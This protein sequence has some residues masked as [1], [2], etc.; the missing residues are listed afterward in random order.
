[1]FE[2]LSPAPPDPILGLTEAYKKDPRP[3]KVNL[4]VGVYQN[5]NGETPILRAVKAAE[6]ALLEIENTKNYLPIPGEPDFARCVE[7]FLF[8]DRSVATARTA[9]AVGGTGALR[10][11]AQFLAEATPN[12]TVWLSAPTW[13]NHRGIFGAA[14][15][16]IQSYPYYDARARRLD[17]PA[18]AEALE[19]VP[20][21]DVVLLHLGCHNPTGADP[22]LDQW[23]KIAEIA[24][25]RGW[26]P[27]FDAAYI[28][29]GDGVEQD[30]S[31]LGVFL[32][33][34]LELLIAT[35]FAKNIMLYGERAGALTLVARSDAAA[36]AA[37]SRIK[38]VIRT[39]YSSPPAHG[40]RI[41]QMV[42]SDPIL[43]TMW[44]DELR[45]M[46]AR[47]HDMRS[48]LA[49]GL[50]V[51]LPDRD[52]SHI[53][54]QRGMFSYSGLTS[55]QTAWLRTE[56]A[57]YMTDDGRI[58]VAGVTTRTLNYVCDAIAEAVRT[59]RDG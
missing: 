28:G 4:G 55:P 38:R 25:R 2:G 49:V 40:G 23:K 48:R 50:A 47:I 46:C 3:E 57:I 6:A 39:L 7:S 8:G 9:Q 16:Q 22:T 20:A 35:S 53:R 1:M 29:L 10:V 5:D 41:V 19:R 37:F 13:P 42:F 30:R 11:M 56:R 14:G 15:L 58:N 45:E 52:F 54:A 31:P 17:F 12:A 51:R 26:L 32:D 36:D 21:G 18:L 34:A 44:R 24:G 59:V 27:L 43:R 33:A